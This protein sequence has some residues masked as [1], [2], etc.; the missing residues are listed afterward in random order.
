[1][2]TSK[3]SAPSTRWN[4]TAAAI[5]RV[6]PRARRTQAVLVPRDDPRALAGVGGAS[7]SPTSA[8]SSVDFPAF[9]RPAM[10]TRSGPVEPRP[11]RVDLG[12]E[13][14][15]R[16]GRAGGEVAELRTWSTAVSAGV[17]S[18]RRRPRPSAA[19]WTS[20]GRS[21]SIRCGAPRVAAPR[22]RGLA[23]VAAPAGLR[24]VGVRALQLG[25]PFGELVA[26]RTLDV[27]ERLADLVADLELHVVG[28]L[29]G[30]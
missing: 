4:G 11:D 2:A 21:R 18:S 10:A 17:R 7:R 8:L 9:T 22:V 30:R 12:G 14:R 19:R 6:R 20:V 16:P 15:V 26:D 27:A 25:D 28:E 1:M 24:R 3:R 13:R 29:A 5:R 23:R